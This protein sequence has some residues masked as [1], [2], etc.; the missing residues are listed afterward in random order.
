MLP[1]SEETSYCALRTAIH[2]DLTVQRYGLELVLIL[3]LASKRP[4]LFAYSM[5]AIVN[6]YLTQTSE[7][8]RPPQKGRI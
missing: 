1:T 2:E 5:N 4:Q 3:Q 6:T 8:Q 7:S